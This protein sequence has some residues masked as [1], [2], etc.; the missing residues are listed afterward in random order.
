MKNVLIGIFSIPIAIL[1]GCGFLF[2]VQ[3]TTSLRYSYGGAISLLPVT[4]I[5]FGL[6]SVVVNVYALKNS[7]AYKKS[8]VATLAYFLPLASAILS[9]GAV[10][11]GLLFA[12]DIFG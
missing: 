5:V 11:Y 6:A 7:H 3:E 1:L 12:A 8:S 2:T 9:A 4:I 10:L